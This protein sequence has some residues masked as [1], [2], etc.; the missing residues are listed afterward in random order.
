MAP[1]VRAITPSTISLPSESTRIR[2]LD[3]TVITV[4][5][6]VFADLQLINW[7]RCDKML[8]STV[9]GLRYETT[10]DQLLNVLAKMRRICFAHPKIETDSGTRSEL[11]LH[12]TDPA[13][14]V[15]HRWTE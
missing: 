1:P 8:I 5:N 15:N 14:T 12:R 4:P 2:A 13:P 9:I 11:F 3:R 7:A 6:S 10:P